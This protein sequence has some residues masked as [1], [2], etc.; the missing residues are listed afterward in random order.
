MSNK[1]I[2]IT[3]AAGYLGSQL[4]QRLHAQHTVI[5]TDIRSRTDVAFPIFQVDI[6]SPELHNIIANH[7]ITQ[8]V[9]LASIVEPS[10]DTVRDYDIDVN[11]TRNLLAACVAHGV[12]HITVTSSGA[13]YGYHPDNPAWLKETDALRGNSEFSYAFHKRE[14]ENLLADYR[15]RAPSLKQ[16]IF[17]PGTVLGTH[18]Q[19]MI[20]KLFTGRRLLAIQGS[21]SPFVFIWDQDVVAAIEQGIN[22]NQAGIFNMA[23]DGALT[24]SDIASRLGKPLIALPA[25]LVKAALS[26]G[27]GMGLTRYGPSQINFLRYRPVLDNTALKQDFGYTPQKTSAEV[28][29]YFMSH[30]QALRAARQPHER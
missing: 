4:G 20:T 2:L 23:G 9:H 12:Q 8:V 21:D 3:G 27:N 16:L 15:V 19:N 28:F 29:E 22:Q 10:E 5:G 30:G 18:T 13:A 26:V 11:G 24:M 17:R 6:R 7:R 25:W 1:R 14:V